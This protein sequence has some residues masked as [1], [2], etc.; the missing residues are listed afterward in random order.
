MLSGEQIAAHLNSA[1]HQDGLSQF[2]GYLHVQGSC[3]ERRT[4]FLKRVNLV[5]IIGCE[6]R[7]EQNAYADGDVAKGVGFLLV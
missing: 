1:V 7:H 2:A 4:K 6:G 5:Q 3:R